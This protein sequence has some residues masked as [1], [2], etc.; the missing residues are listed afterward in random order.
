MTIDIISMWRY[1]G[2]PQGQAF[3][4]NVKRGWV[5]KAINGAD[6]L[7]EDLVP[8]ENTQEIVNYK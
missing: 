7:T 3:A 2:D 5:V 8:I 1:P 6:V 4:A